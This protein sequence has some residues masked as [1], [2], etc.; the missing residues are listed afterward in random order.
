MSNNLAPENVSND[1]SCDNSIAVKETKKRMVLLKNFAE[2]LDKEHVE[3]ILL[4][5]SLAY[6]ANTSVRENSDIDIVVCYDDIK[7][8]AKD[9]FNEAFYL[10]EESYDGYLVKR[11]A[12]VGHS[13]YIR[14]K[15]EDRINVSI[16]NINYS[17]LQRISYGNYETL[18]YYRQSQKGSIYT[19]RD[20]DG[21]QYPY[22]PQC[23]QV[24][25]VIG[26]RRIDCVAFPSSDGHY[27]IGN[28][29]DKL[30]SNAKIIYDKS[31]KMHNIMINLWE[32]VAKKIIRHRSYNQQSI[33]ASNEDIGP[34]LFRY[35]RFSDK[36]KEITKERTATAIAA[37]LEGYSLESYLERKPQNT[38]DDLTW[39]QTVSLLN[40]GRS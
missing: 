13:P 14:D 8:C 11:H 21:N 6:A 15:N 20:F 32:S 5:G 10:L 17:A 24:K 28:D 35:D 31:K 25:G 3:G 7:N 19:M 29:M 40:D 30:L 1:N 2:A 26:E 27:I 12:N 16:H 4:V 33:I 23:E 37:V 38:K 39:Y 36:A 9:Y 22:K 34:L 18:A